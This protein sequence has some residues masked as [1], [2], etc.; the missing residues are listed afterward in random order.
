MLMKS[1][2]LSLVVV[3]LLA[4]AATAS[5]AGPFSGFG[6]K[7]KKAKH[8]ALKE[9]HRI[10]DR[11]AQGTQPQNQPVPR[12]DAA[13]APNSAAAETSTESW[14]PSPEER[15]RSGK[16][17]A[18]QGALQSP[19]A[20]IGIPPAAVP[21]VAT[22]ATV[23]AMAIWPALLKAIATLLKGLTAGRLRARARRDKKIDPN[24]RHFVVMG[25]RLRPVE[26]GSLF[27]ASCI[28]GL[29]LCYALQ[30]WALAPAFVLQQTT[31][32]IGIYFL[33]S[34]LRFAYERKFGLV[35][36]FRFW[37]AGCLI[38]LCSAFLGG[39][40]ATSGYELESTQGPD[41][42]ERAMR[43]KVGLLMITFGLALLFFLANLFF[44][45]KFFQMGRVLAS[46]IAL[47]E[48]FPLTPMPGLR[49]YRWRRGVWA[50][51][52]ALIV[53]SFFVIN[54]IL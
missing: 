54:F 10:F 3:L 25:F 8:T 41:A 2:A 18:M 45:Q 32:V 13:G 40:L 22:V 21:A 35:T 6:K 23:G 7:V 16:N 47:A 11:P 34:F 37:P 27:V 52:F 24:Q 9:A 51:L 15:V 4:L 49:I 29:A 42:A 28:Y 31:I 50:I 30:G 46:G 17:Y 5:A 44:P 38:C 26:L 43:L 36:V 48:V 12:P 14:I 53:P 33:R 20:R 1:K 39:T 19:L